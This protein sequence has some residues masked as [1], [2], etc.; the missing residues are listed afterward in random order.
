MVG[1]R[2]LK[3][4]VDCMDSLLLGKKLSDSESLKASLA[5]KK[6]QD[7]QKIAVEVSVQ[8]TS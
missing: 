2:F 6:V 7:L 8:L 5:L 1:K 4:A 3:M